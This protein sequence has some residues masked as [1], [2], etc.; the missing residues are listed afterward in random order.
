MLEMKYFFLVIKMLSVIS[1]FGQQPT[2]YLIPGQGSDYR[3]Y[4]NLTIPY[5][6]V[7][8]QYF[9]PSEVD[10]MESFAHQLAKQI[11]TTSPYGIIGVSLGGMLAS[12]MKEFLNPEFVIVV[13]SAK[14]REELPARYR[15]ME[16]VPVNQIFSS[17][18]YKNGALLAQ[19]LVEPDRKLEEE[20]FKSMLKDKDPDFLKRTAGIII[21]WNRKEAPEGIYHIHGNNDNTIPL[22]NVQADVVIED[23]SHMMMLTKGDTLSKIISGRIYEILGE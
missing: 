11:D 13:S 2:V 12:E 23:G 7:H 1:V 6:T 3:L 4:N 22:R 9:T 18:F 20:T 10:S 21:N 8:V 17:E 19:P 14:C 15:F 5:D 16:K